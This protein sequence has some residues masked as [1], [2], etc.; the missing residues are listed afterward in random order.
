M[1]G[2]EISIVLQIAAVRAEAEIAASYAAAPGVRLIPR[3]A[4][5]AKA[6]RD[7]LVAAL[8]TL[9]RLQSVQRIHAAIDP[10]PAE[11]E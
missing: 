1:T 6:R 2:P 11:V 9:E 3:L 5:P 8:K 7:A 10:L 4:G